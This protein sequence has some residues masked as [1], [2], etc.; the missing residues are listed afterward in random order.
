MPVSTHDQPRAG[1]GSATTHFAPAERA[2]PED[3]AAQIGM[4]CS[5]PL[6]DV[7]LQS[8]GGIVLIL[9]PQ[10]QIVA[11]N[12]TVMRILGIEDPET[13]YGLRPGDALACANAA[14][15]PNGCGTGERCRACG[16]VVAILASQEHQRPE[17]RECLITSHLQGKLVAFEFKARATPLRSDGQTFTVVTLQDIRAE[18]RKEMLQRVFFHDVLN[19]VSALQG[20]AD[21]MTEAAP[22]EIEDLAQSI[23][24]K[25]R[26]LG[27]EIKGQR[28]L[29]LLEDGEYP[30][31]RAE[32][33]PDIIL[34]AL[35]ETFA[36][37]E[38]ARDR[39]LDLPADP[40]PL[41]FST[42]I[43]L[44]LR[45]LVNMVK[46]ALEATPSGGRVKV[47]VEADDGDII[48]KVWNEEEI[49]PAVALRIFQRY[50]STKGTGRGLGTFSLKLIGEQYLKG[51]VDFSTSRDGTTFWIRLPV[52]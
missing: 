22:E 32:T 16:A 5:N 12:K 25:A 10:R 33:T 8:F 39:A 9:N 21:Y 27:D 42:D 52:G 45:V 29:R 38:V 40:L 15:A 24:R 18:K 31:R 6:A 20:T 4:A 23:Q 11:I 41:S 14:E 44:L 46:N 26:Q 34:G 19:L 28:D 50:F 1:K 43:S 48:F 47:W 2:S 35:R 37:A 49:P 30:L 17:E 36:D 13:L 51:A 3:L 7:I